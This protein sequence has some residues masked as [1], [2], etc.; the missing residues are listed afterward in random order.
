[1]AAE[2]SSTTQ[3]S[4][5]RYLVPAQTNNRETKPSSLTIARQNPIQH[6]ASKI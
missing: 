6:Q 3:R 4:L 5:L 1:M 2:S